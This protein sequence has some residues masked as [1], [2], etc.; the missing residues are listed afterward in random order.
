MGEGPETEL[1]RAERRVRECEERV[2]RLKPLIPIMELV[3][4]RRAAWTGRHVLVNLQ[5][6]LE[7]SR[8]HLERLRRPGGR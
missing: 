5:K 8:A 6:T 1:E 2:A 4:H 3:R 7:R